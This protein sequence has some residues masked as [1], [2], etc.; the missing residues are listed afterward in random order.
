MSA[1]PTP[2]SPYWHFDRASW[3]QLR[4]DEAMPLSDEDLAALAGTIE[5]VSREEI[6]AIY[7]PLS[8]LLSLY[9]QARLGLHRVAGEF[10]GRTE[11]KVPYIIGVAGSVAVGKSTTSRV[12]QALLSRWE[13]HPRVSVLTTDAFLHPNA[14]LEERGIMHRKGFPESYDLQALLQVLSAVKSGQGDMAVP[15][16]S[17]H[18]YDIMSDKQSCIDQPDILIIEGLNILQTG[19]ATGQGHSI[20]VSD[21]LDFSIF[22]DAPADIIREWYVERFMA[23]RDSA[24][25]QPDAFFHRFIQLTQE[26]AIKTAERYWDEINAINLYENILPYQGRATLQLKKEVGHAVS[27]VRL[28]RL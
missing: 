25:Q 4:A 13:S 28:R 10:V 1:K 6:E 14:V 19:A 23:L 20:F 15:V 16:Y 3:Q 27:E 21:Y 12:L 8:R 24:F 11:P 2:L 7:L 26:E 18:Y 22:V 9:V 17:H 5:A